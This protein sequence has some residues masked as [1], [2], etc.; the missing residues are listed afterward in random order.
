MVPV[1]PTVSRLLDDGGSTGFHATS[2]GGWG[3]YEC[4][5]LRSGQASARV[6]EEQASVP[7]FQAQISPEVTDGP[8]ALVGPADPAV[9]NLAVGLAGFRLTEAIT[10]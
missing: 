8:C 4:H 10:R 2:S 1:P 6:F 7:G 9:G 5:C 3:R